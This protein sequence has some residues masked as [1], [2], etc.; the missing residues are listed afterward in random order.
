MS[1]LGFLPFG[2]HVGH[3][4]HHPVA[5]TVFIVVPGKGLYKVIIESNANHSINDR[6]VVV[7][8]E[9]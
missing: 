7:A 6:G 3:E 2:V 8:I 1:S 5:V 9:V 4:F